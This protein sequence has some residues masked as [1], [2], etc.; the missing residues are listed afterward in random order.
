MEFPLP[1]RQDRGFLQCET[2]RLQPP[3]HGQA[4]PEIVPG[5]RVARLQRHG[6][7]VGAYGV[8]RPFERHQ[9]AAVVVERSGIIRRKDKRPLEPVQSL[10][11][12]PHGG[13]DAREA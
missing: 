7:L 9:G 13:D 5:G 12:P 6:A 1:R 2:R 4:V 3:F 10:C 11:L 8:G